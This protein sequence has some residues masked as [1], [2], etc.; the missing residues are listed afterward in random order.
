M[1]VTVGWVDG[2]DTK[3]LFT[4]SVTQACA[5][6]ALHHRLVSILRVQ[7]GPLLCEGRNLLVSQFLETGADWL[8]MVDT[9]M[10]F[11][12]DVV[13]R[14][15]VTAESEQVKVVGGLAYGV[16]HELGQFPTL[17]RQIDGMPQVLLNQPSG[18]VDVDATGAAFTLTH[19]SVFVDYARQDHHRW[20]HR[21]VVPAT[22]THPG[23]V[24]GED[25]SWCWHLRANGVRI[26]VDTAVEAGHV[27]PTLVNSDTYKALHA[28]H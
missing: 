23:G 10:V 16:N 5:Y 14:L 1:T 8:F 26:V 7:S 21:A 9:D 15:L 4:K 2:G 12:H 22:E 24:L 17:Y 25:I 27:K 19:R 6:E 20:F 18:I 13:E 28:A 3:G 11:D